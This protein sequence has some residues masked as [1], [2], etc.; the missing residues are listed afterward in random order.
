MSQSLW[1]KLGTPSAVQF[2]LGLL[3]SPQSEERV[4]RFNPNTLPE[5]LSKTGAEGFDDITKMR[6]Q[7]KPVALTKVDEYGTLN[8]HNVRRYEIINNFFKPIAFQP[9]SGLQGRSSKWLDSSLD[10]RP[11][12]SCLAGQG[13]ENLEFYSCRCNLNQVTSPKTR[14]FTSYASLDEEAPKV[15]IPSTPSSGPL[16]SFSMI[17]PLR[18]QAMELVGED[19]GAIFCFS[20]STFGCIA[21][22]Y[23]SEAAFMESLNRVQSIG[24]ALIRMH[25]DTY[26]AEKGE[27]IKRFN[28]G[29]ALLAQLYESVALIGQASDPLFLTH[30]IWGVAVT[31]QTRGYFLC[32]LGIV[33]LGID[34]LTQRDQSDGFILVAPNPAKTRFMVA[35][36]IVSRS[37]FG[38]VDILP[39]RC[40]AYPAAP[41]PWYDSLPV[42]S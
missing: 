22:L 41:L 9:D 32:Q 16:E 35:N 23:W 14:S 18:M 2:Q 26:A 39:E 30:G 17:N 11:L 34:S 1:H 25:A 40:E 38:F 28:S 12:G 15:A 13:G 31:P 19:A 27:G 21:R 6:E 37:H 3:S 5:L 36:F 4:R 33:A 7:S 20:P 29:S 42:L 10:V 24:T 8:V